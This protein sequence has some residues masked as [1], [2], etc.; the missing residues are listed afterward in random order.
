MAGDVRERGCIYR[1]REEIPSSILKTQLNWIV[2]EK[3]N[4]TRIVITFETLKVLIFLIYQNNS[5]NFF[6]NLFKIENKVII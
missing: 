6:V 1:R 4:K 5:L 2:S 3:Q